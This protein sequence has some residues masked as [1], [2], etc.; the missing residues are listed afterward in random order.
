MWLCFHLT[1]LFFYSNGIYLEWNLIQKNLFLKTPLSVFLSVYLSIYPFVYL[2]SLVIL[3]TGQG[4]R[5]EA[6]CLEDQ[7][8]WLWEMTPLT[9]DSV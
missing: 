3:V 8:L 2:F 7:W 9:L 1:I 4:D 6:A 5:G